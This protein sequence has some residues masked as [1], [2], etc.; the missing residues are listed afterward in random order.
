MI[1]A[2]FA[3]EI[4]N[5]LTSIKTF[6]QLLPERYSDTDFRENF[7]RLVIDGVNR[8]DGL[9]KDLLDFSSGRIS[10]ELSPVNVTEIMDKVVDEVVTQIQLKGRKIMIEKDY[11]DIEIDMMGDGKRLRQ[12]FLNIIFN[13]CQAIPESRDDGKITVSINPGKENVG[14]LIADN[15]EGI[16]PEDIPRIFEPFFS[17]K[18]VGAGLGLA[19]TKKIIENHYGKIEVDSILKKGT[20]FKITLPIKKI[21]AKVANLSTA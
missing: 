13:A 8:I 20:I 12:A 16:P 11:N 7:S 21:G 5:P 19:I 14:I 15:G 1:S 18:T 6:A 2:T 9:I 3:H 10:V 4:K 17:K